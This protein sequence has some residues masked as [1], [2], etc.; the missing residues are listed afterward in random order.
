MIFSSFSFI[1]FLIAVL[2]LYAAARSY[3]QRATI[4]LVASI[5]FYAS[6]QPVYLLL[7][8]ASLGVNYLIYLRLSVSRRRA[9]LVLGLI[10]NLGALG[11]F[12]YLGLFIETSSALMSWAG[13]AALREGR[14]AWVNWALPLGISFYTFHMLSVMMDVYRGDWTRRISF[15]A[16]TMYVTF[17]PHMIAGPILRASELVEQLEVLKPLRTEH[18]RAGLPIFIGGLVKK[19]LLADNLAPLADKLYAH[20]QGLDFTMAWAGTSAFGL[21]IYFDFSG[22]SEMAIGIALIF[23]VTLP[24]N[25][26]YPYISRSLREFWQRWHITLSRWLRDYLYIP[27]GGSRGSLS[28][29]LANLITTMLLG[30]LWHGAGWN[31]AFWG[32]LHGVYLAGHRLLLRLYAFMGVREGTPVSAVLSWLG[33]PLT[34]ILVSFSWVFFR[35][36][37]FPDAWTISGAMLGFAQ[38]VQAAETLRKFEVALVG[39]AALVVFIEPIFVHKVTKLYPDGWWRV[40]FVAR[41]LAYA[42]LVITLLVFGGQTQKFIYFDF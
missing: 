42:A 17:F 25:F 18:L 31:F 24:R 14:P 35:A 10:L 15:R 40:P 32:L 34:L 30:G 1:V 23:G 21:Q 27:L 13:H 4:V 19:A 3:A 41:G 12:K 39:L 26:M 38:P 5:I 11:A 28:R 7:L 37:S 8:F 29:N 6:W 9:W 20:P 22:Y 33:L 2:S 16:W 36:T